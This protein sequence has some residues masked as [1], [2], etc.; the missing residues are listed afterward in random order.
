MRL[1]LQSLIFEKFGAGAN[2]LADGDSGVEGRGVRRR[3]VG[4]AP[5]SGKK[6]ASAGA[7]RSAARLGVGREGAVCD[8]LPH[9]QDGGR[10][11]G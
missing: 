8:R 1:Q 5:G 7:D 6:R 4:G 11:R 9:R 2:D 3:K 10:W